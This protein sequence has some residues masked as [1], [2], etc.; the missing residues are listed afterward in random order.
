MQSQSQK[1]LDEGQK[2]ARNAWRT[3]RRLENWSLGN[4][5]ECGHRAGGKVGSYEITK[6]GSP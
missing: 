5:G 2:R 3:Q 1:E 6:T 4:K